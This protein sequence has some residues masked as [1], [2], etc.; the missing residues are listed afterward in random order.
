MNNMCDNML[1]QE[2]AAAILRMQK[3]CTDEDYAYIKRVLYSL[4]P[5]GTLLP[6]DAFEMIETYVHTKDQ[7]GFCRLFATLTGT[8]WTS[9]MEQMLQIVA[10]VPMASPAKPVKHPTTC[11]AS[12]LK[13]MLGAK[14]K[15][16]GE[17]SRRLNYIVERAKLERGELARRIGI[18]RTTMYRYML[19]PKDSE[20]SIPKEET[21]L[22]IITALPVENTQFWAYPSDFSAWKA[23]FKHTK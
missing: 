1:P 3:R 23:Q 18:S 17:F 22:A 7:Q 13:I 9:F 6:F 8:S 15:Q 12:G 19:S 4:Q 5:N 2:M 10:I 20:F 16:T 11:V 21:A 14:G